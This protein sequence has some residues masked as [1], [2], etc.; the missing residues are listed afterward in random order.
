MNKPATTI[1]DPDLVA[2]AARIF[3]EEALVDYRTAKLKAA[4]RLGL[5]QRGTALP[6]NETI[7]K[8]VV[9]YQQLYGGDNYRTRLEQLRRAAVQAMELLAD[10]Q[11]RLVGPVVSGAI[12]DGH[13]VQLHV[14]ADAPEMVDIH[15]HNLGVAC[16]PADRDYRH[17]DG[18]QRRIPIT[19]FMVG[20]V[21]VD[22]AV[23]DPGQRSRPPLSPVDGRPQRGLS[24]S[25]ARELL[26]AG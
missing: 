20:G 25:Q 19:S 6:D 12:T 22:V 7:S 9:E 2:E 14:F 26:I 23:F 3:C 21:G 18:R 15:L 17:A 1:V 24:P 4:R 11:P 5:P 8:A 16:Y 13:R 10:F